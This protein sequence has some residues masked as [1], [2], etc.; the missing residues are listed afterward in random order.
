MD[1][2][3]LRRHHDWAAKLC[4]RILIVPESRKQAGHTWEWFKTEV[5][6]LV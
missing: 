5:G 4:P 2:E 3:S 6:Q 1:V